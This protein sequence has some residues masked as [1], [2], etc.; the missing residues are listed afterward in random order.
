[1]FYR[2][3]RP[4]MI[5]SM[6]VGQHADT[7]FHFFVPQLSPPLTYPSTFHPTT[8]GLT[9]RAAHNPAMLHLQQLYNSNQ[10]HPSSSEPK[11]TQSYIGLIAMAILSSPD[12]QL[13]LSD[14]Y[15]WIVDNF[16][17]FRMR[18]SGWKNSIRHNLSLNDCFI[19]ADRCPN[20]KGH[21]WTIHPANR[22]D[23]VK[24]DFRRRRAQQKVKRHRQM[25]SLGVSSAV[26]AGDIMSSSGS[27]PEEEKDIVSPVSCCSYS[28]TEPT[29]SPLCTVTAGGE[30]QQPLSNKPQKKRPFDIESLLGLEPSKKTCKQQLS[31]AT[32]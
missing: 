19:K 29:V 26:A 31:F 5:C 6:P 17:Y 2:M 8:C 27:E 11:P 15:Q 4:D 14:I 13:I 23:F 1:M 9:L 32:E 3:F 25:L 7:R 12:R 20:G 30:K 10:H 18:G 16:V 24:G 21:Y 22:D 28:S